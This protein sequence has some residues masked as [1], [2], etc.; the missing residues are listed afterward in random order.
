MQGYP[1]PGQPAQPG[2]PVAPAPGHVP[3]APAQ[4]VPQPAAAPAPVPAAAPAI[5]GT[6][7]AGPAPTYGFMQEAERSQKAASSGLSLQGLNLPLLQV[8]ADTSGQ[9]VEF[10]F[11]ILPSWEG[12]QTGQLTEGPSIFSARVY[13][14]PGG[15]MNCVFSP[16][17]Q[18][19]GTAVAA[20]ENRFNAHLDQVLAGLRFKKTDELKA[21]GANA[22]AEY[23]SLFNDSLRVLM[24]VCPCDPQTGAPILDA[25]GQPQVM[26][27]M[28]SEK[29]WED[30]GWK[31]RIRS[32]VM[33]HHFAP[34]DPRHGCVL[35]GKRRGSKMQDT[36]YVAIDPLFGGTPYALFRDANNQP[37]EAMIQA[38]LSKVLPWNQVMHCPTPEEQEAIIA[39]CYEARRAVLDQAI[40]VASGL[41]APG[42]QPGA[43]PVAPAPMVI[44][45]THIPAAGVP[46]AAGAPPMMPAPAA[47]AGPVQPGVAP[48]QPHTQLATPPAGAPVPVAPAPA[49]VAPAAAPGTTPTMPPGFGTQPPGAPAAPMAPAPAAPMAPAAP[50]APGMAPPPPPAPAVPG[51][52]APAYA[53]PPPAPGAP[54]PPMPQSFPGAAPPGVAPGQPGV[55]AAPPIPASPPDAPA[56]QQPG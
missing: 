8:P 25:S 3:A 11:W 18:W 39:P 43:Q 27:W 40:A 16:D 21:M 9:G 53:P 56:F 13:M 36:S 24:Q 50:A 49:P 19:P 26:L 45:G 22:V 41:V 28:P 47:G 1:P 42:V 6:A 23:R 10:A 38:V 35:R 51:V 20:Y 37:D 44:P 5:P 46:A 29:F 12:I 14:R 52:S 48:P 2:Y 17:V 30:H 7:P 54:T 32:L 4:G 33:T 31:D 34:V 55:P 15:T